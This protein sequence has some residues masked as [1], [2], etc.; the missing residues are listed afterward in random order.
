[1]KKST[2]LKMKFAVFRSTPIYDIVSNNAF[3]TEFERV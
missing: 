1:M 3:H 2:V